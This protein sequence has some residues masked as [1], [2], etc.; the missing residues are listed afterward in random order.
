MTECVSDG[1]VM[2]VGVY[3]SELGG[4]GISS[5]AKGWVGVGWSV[6]WSVSGGGRLVERLEARIRMW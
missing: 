2:L 6:K 3:T 1:G 5:D 4:V